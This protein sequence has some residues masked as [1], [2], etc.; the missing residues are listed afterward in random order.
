MD[1]LH[2]ITQQL[3]PASSADSA[4]AVN[5]TA[6]SS[7]KT[8]SFLDEKNS[9]NEKPSDKIKRYLQREEYGKLRSAKKHSLKGYTLFVT[10]AS[11]GIGLAIALRAARD[12]ANV[13]VAAKT[14]TEDKRL[15]GTIYTAAEEIEKAGGKALPVQLDIRDENAVKQAVDKAVKH[16]G[17]IDILVNNAS[18]ISLTDSQDTT[19]KKFDL[20]NQINHRGTFLV[21]KY[22]IPHLR[23]SAEQG[24]SPHILNLG[25]PLFNIADERWFAPS[26]AYSI[27]KFNM[28]LQVLGLAGENRSY[29]VAANSLWPLTVIAT[30]AVQNLLGGD[31]SIARSRK[32][33]VMAD[34]AYAILTSD[35]KTVTGYYFVDEA[36]LRAAGVTDFSPYKFNQKISDDE[37]GLDFFV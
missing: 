17:G 9:E 11:R 28:S 20:M 7:N 18:A 26:T 8:P 4:V 6:A 37:L 29:G 15:P 1:R 10:G 21:S 25:P 22:V 34:S 5:P 24:K 27:A 13:V 23:K 35:S 32:P 33:T 16:F 2:H 14:V 31:D 19:M 3:L 36:T 12:G 30:A